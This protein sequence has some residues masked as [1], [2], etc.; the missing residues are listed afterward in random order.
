MLKKRLLSRSRDTLQLSNTTPMTL[1]DERYRAVKN[2]QQFLSRLAG[3]QY[4]RVP[5][6]VRAEAR[7]ILRHYPNDW[8]MN[9]A[10][11]TS[12]DIF[13]ERMEDLHRFVAA[14]A[15]ARD[16]TTVEE[17]VQGYREI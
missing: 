7:S 2:A 9:R 5:K 12:P 10:A 8:D 4:A 16:D 11:Q 13:A 15:A 14:G 3:G 17:L 6:A 1:P